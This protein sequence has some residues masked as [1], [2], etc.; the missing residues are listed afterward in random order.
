MTMYRE[1]FQEGLSLSDF[2]Q[3]F[4]T[5]DHCV[6]ALEYVRWLDDGL[7]C[8]QCEGARHS[9]LKGCARKIFQCG[10]GH[11]QNSL[12]AGIL[13]QVTNLPLILWFLSIYLV[14]QLKSGLSVL[15]LSHQH[16]VSN[17]LQHGASI[18]SPCWSNAQRPIPCRSSYKSTVLIWMEENPAIYRKWISLIFVKLLKVIPLTL[19]YSFNCRF[20]PAKLPVRPAS[21]RI[22]HRNKALELV[23]LN[24]IIVLTRFFDFRSKR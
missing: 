23:L 4:G 9:V 19:F 11:L 15:A 13:L 5:E 7:R 20:N 16:C 24:E 10:H 3:R 14:S 17:F 21:C 22:E 1:Q 6:T 12:I 2:M 18:T 8:P